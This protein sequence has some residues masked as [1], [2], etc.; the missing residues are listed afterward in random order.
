MTIHSQVSLEAQLDMPIF[1]F[2]HFLAIT[3][4]T[5]L[6]DD[7]AQIAK[8]FSITYPKEVVKKKSKKGHKTDQGT[9]FQSKLFKQVLRTLN[10]NHTVSSAYHPES[11][12]TLERWHPTLKS[13]LRNRLPSHLVLCCFPFPY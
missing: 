8:Y 10:I 3:P 1:D 12:G 2:K 9:N 6:K 11:Q 7:L 4:L 13:T 5:N